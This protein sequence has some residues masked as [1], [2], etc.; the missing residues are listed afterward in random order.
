MISTTLKV[1]SLLLPIATLTICSYILHNLYTDLS[2]LRFSVNSKLDVDSVNILLNITYNGRETLKSFTLTLIAGD[3]SETYVLDIKEG[4]TTL[5]YTIP[6]ENV[7]TS[8]IHVRPSL[9]YMSIVRISIATPK[10][11]ISW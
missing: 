5:I 7:F 8:D 2:S 6:L 10:L 4:S 1:C 3:Y 9:N 11:N